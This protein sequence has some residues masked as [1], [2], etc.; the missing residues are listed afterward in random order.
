LAYQWYF[1]ETNSLA[2]ETNATLVLSNITA[3]Q[4]GSYLVVVTNGYGSVTSAPALVSVGSAPQL[5]STPTNQTA[6]SGDTVTFSASALGTE[7]L[8]YQWYFNV[9]NALDSETN[10]VLV[11]SNVAPQQAGSYT[12]VITNLYGS[13]ASPPAQLFLLLPPL[14]V[15]GPVSQVVSNGATVS[16]S[17]AAQGS[18]PLSYQWYF[19]T[20]NLLNGFT[21]A[22]CLL[23][24]VGL[25]NA[26]DY[27]V[28]V[29]N[30]FGSALSQ[31]ATLRV[32]V[33]PQIISVTQSGSVLS[34]T[35]TTVAGLIYEVYYKDDLTSTTWTALPKRA[36]LRLGTGAPMTVTDL[37]GP[38]PSRFY[39]VIVQ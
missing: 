30:A 31:P 6:F 26:G 8:H 4:A 7:P 19:N 9:T 37:I 16:F 24:N 11:L 13:V 10:D 18:P 3:A 15:S 17:V 23:T 36:I 38:N 22:S 28:S 20:T 14:I 33:P 39:T 29:S 34:L 2:L 12:V 1:D 35:F 21:N 5:T 27:S 25:A 32:L